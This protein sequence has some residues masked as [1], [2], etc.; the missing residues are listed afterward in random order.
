MRQS[1]ARPIG[2]R[3]LSAGDIDDAESPDAEAH[4]RRYMGAFAVRTAMH[5]R[6]HHAPYHRGVGSAIR[7]V[8]GD[9]AD[10]AHQRSPPADM[11]GARVFAKLELSSRDELPDVLR[12]P[13]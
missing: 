12:A 13:R 2:A 4:A 7:I 11:A 10:A 6:A 1:N 5:E 9:A 3:L 8:L